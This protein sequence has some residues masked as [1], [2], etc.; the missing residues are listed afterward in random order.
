[1]TCQVIAG[2]QISE[3]GDRS[4]AN[5]ETAMSGFWRSWFAIWCLLI[6]IFGVVLA[7]G[8]L[9]ATSGP[10]A[11]LLS[12]LHG[13]GPV[14]FDPTLR[15]SLGVMG[16]VSIG[17][18]VSLYFTI[19]AATNLGDQGRPLWNAVTAGMVSWFVVDGILSV[20]TGFGLN[21][22]P[23]IALAGMYFVGLSGSGVLKRSV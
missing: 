6:G 18:A 16:G 13:Q 11:L 1:M 9:E 23:N 14:S 22:V 7:G 3:N 8:A 21:V 4:E 17:W 20:A 12:V 15:F 2:G 10:V 5:R 19:V